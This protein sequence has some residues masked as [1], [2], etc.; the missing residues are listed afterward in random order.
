VTRQAP[1][2]LGRKQESGRV[3]EIG[4][5]AIEPVPGDVVDPNGRED[6]RH[7]V[8]AEDGQSGPVGSMTLTVARGATWS[9]LGRFGGQFA[10]LAAG[11]VLARLL[12]P[13]DFGILASVYVI[14]GFSV[15]FFEL[16]VSSALVQL[17]DVTEQD[18]ATAFWI[19]AI[20]GVLFTGVLAALGPFVAEVFN[21]PALRVV[22]PICA[23]TF[24]LSFGVVHRALLARQL[25]YR[26]LSLIDLATTLVGYSVSIVLALGGAGYFAL[27]LGPVTASALLSIFY[28]AAFPWRPKYFICRTSLPRLWRFSGGLLGFNVVN[29]IGRNADNLLIAR[30]F[31]AAQLGYYNR[32]YNLMLLPVQQVSGVLGGVMFPALS[33]LQDDRARVAAGYKRAVRLI[34]TATVPLLLGLS[35]TAPGVIPLIWGG[36]WEATVPILQILCL[37]GV[38]QCTTSS[39]GWIFQS[40]NRTGL[41]FRLGLIS[42]GV[43]VVG[44][45]AGFPFGVIGLSVAILISGIVILPINLIPACRLIDLRAGDILRGNLPCVLTAAAMGLTVWGV[46]RLLG[47]DVRAAVVVLAQVAI[48]AVLYLLGTRSFQRDTFDEFV[49]ILRRMRGRA[50]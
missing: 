15:L 4:R 38:T 11:I 22:T 7:D 32:A 45:V 44:I 18:L 16:G 21:Q 14:T 8:A 34:N 6:P 9:A 36:Q 31:G 10:Q 24:G 25:R 20:G 40:Q 37:A 17:K 1:R 28:W 41:M 12:T 33:R 19:N 23:L 42:T 49:G 29:Y 43:G 50:A 27:A 3:D 2:L 39:V 30:Y 46:P 47:L 5:S 48:G 35:A 13:A 26:T